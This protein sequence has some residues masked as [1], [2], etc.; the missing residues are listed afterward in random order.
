MHYGLRS[1]FTDQYRTNA[2]IDEA[3]VEQYGNALAEGYE[4]LTGSEYGWPSLP[5]GLVCDVAIRDLGAGRFGLANPGSDPVGLSDCYLAL[6]SRSLESSSE[7][8]AG[9]RRTI[10]IHELLHLL[11]FPSP[12]YRSGLG[13]S[14]FIKDPNWWLHESVALATEWFLGGASGKLIP[15]L[16]NWANAPHI[17]CQADELGFQAF[18]WMVYLMETFGKWFPARLYNQVLN[19]ISAQHVG[20]IEA[21]DWLA[22]FI[23]TLKLRVDEAS[24]SSQFL[25]YA[26]LWALPYEQLPTWAQQIVQV[27]GRPAWTNAEFVNDSVWRVP[28]IE[29]LGFRIIPIPEEMQINV[30]DLAV[31]FDG[32][33]RS[34]LESIQSA[35][36]LVDQKDHVTVKECD[37]H[38]QKCV[39][40]VS[41]SLAKTIKEAF[42]VIAN[43]NVGAGRG[44]HDLDPISIELA[45]KAE[46]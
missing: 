20:P 44:N 3:V 8:D 27:V 21:S 10:A 25:R 6:T 37:Y 24:L 4:L 19:N 5:I 35:L 17:S 16:W 31:S 43:T 14:V 36:V 18:P 2:I 33:T 42:L 13:K 34:N 40:R 22:G 45:K 30:W 1:D 12:L 11:Q 28:P 23:R 7:H 46:F 26:C 32:H 41:L 38:Q 15:N 9:M 29:R 39:V